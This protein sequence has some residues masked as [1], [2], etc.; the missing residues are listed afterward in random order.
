[1]G[2]DDAEETPGG[3]PDDD[4]ELSYEE[5][6]PEKYKEPYPDDAE[7]RSAQ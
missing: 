2:S 7:Q 3:W 6:D 5:T 4:E 1:M